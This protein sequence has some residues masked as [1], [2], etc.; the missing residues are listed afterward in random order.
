MATSYLRETVELGTWHNWAGQRLAWLHDRLLAGDQPAPG[1]AQAPHPQAGLARS[2]QAAAPVPRPAPPSTPSTQRPPAGAGSL[3]LAAGAFLLVVAGIAFLA[4]TWDLLGPFGQIAVLLALGVA[5]LGATDRLLTRMHGTA[6]SLGVVGTFLVTIAGIGARVLGPDL[7]GP[8]ASLIVAV[9]ILI[10]LCFGAAW[11]RPRCAPVGELAGVTGATAASVML[12]SAPADDALPFTEPWTW[13]VALV[14]GGVGVLLLLLADRARLKSWP[15]LATVLLVVASIALAFTVPEVEAPMAAGLMLVAVVAIALGRRVLPHPSPVAVAMLAVWVLALLTAWGSSM[16]DPSHRPWGAAALAV[17]GFLAL[18]PGLFRLSPRWLHGL[19]LLV[20]GAAIGSAAGLLVAPWVNPWDEYL[21]AAQWATEA[22]PPWRGLI[23]GLA[24][25]GV[26]A[27]A[28]A[29]TPT[30]ER[31]V[32]GDDGNRFD[33]ARP[34]W[35][36]ALPLVPAAAALVTWLIAVDNDLSDVTQR[37]LSPA[38]SYY[39]SQPTPDAVLHQVAIALAVVAVGILGI[40]LLMRLPAWAVWLVPVLSIPALL[41]EL[42]TRTVDSEWRP[43]LV[44]LLIAVP[45][46]VT[47]VAW[48]WLRRPT[49]SSTWLTLAPPFVLALLPSTLALLDDA[50]N[51]WWFSEDPGTAFQVRTVALLVIG[52]AAAVIGARQRWVGLFGP[53]LVLTV[54]V[55]GIQM[56]DLGRFLPQWVSFGIAGALLLAAG[57]RWEWVRDRGR[58]GAAWVRTMR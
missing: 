24:V 55:V 5:C 21:T 34:R 48:W 19:A 50:T 30:A 39:R 36:A 17:A 42:S 20:G 2:G 13:W 32:A 4:F 25:V 44:G 33:T 51:R 9:G 10:A 40:A 49:R 11:L 3:L 56:A 18:V 53:G 45:A 16:S 43:E 12:V 8:T 14:S 52:A 31:M 47:S 41:V 54:V 29:L 58:S 23:S 57:A 6:T 28:V 7:I 1:E 27:A 35:L 37:G 22:M 38:A 15:W 26:L 46:L